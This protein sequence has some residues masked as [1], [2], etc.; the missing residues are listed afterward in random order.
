MPLGKEQS[1]FVS[2]VVKISMFESTIANS[3]ACLLRIELTLME[4]NEGLHGLFCCI[5]LNR[6]TELVDSLH[7][8]L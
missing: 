6:D 2:A 8:M 5:S 4:A 3:S 1:S 7:N